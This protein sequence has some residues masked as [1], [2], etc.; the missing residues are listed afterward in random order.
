MSFELTRLPNHFIKSNGVLLVG[1]KRDRNWQN[2][3][4]AK[5]DT[6]Y[7]NLNV[8]NSKPVQYSL[9]ILSD[10]IKKLILSHES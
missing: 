9:N 7:T 5:T 6:F 1:D 8:G 3:T 10:F 4:S 2:F